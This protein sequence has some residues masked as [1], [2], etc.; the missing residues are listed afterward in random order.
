MSD[1]RDCAALR[2]EVERLEA[3]NRWLERRVVQVER[4]ARTTEE[5]HR[6][7]Q[8]ALSS[9]HERLRA[10]NESLEEALLAKDRFLAT[11]SH[12]IRTPM[13]GVIGFI[14]LLQGMELEAE[15]AGMVGTLRRS[16]ETLMALLNDVLDFA[17]IEAG[18]LLLEST[19]F[20][21]VDRLEDLREL[22]R[23]R[24]V[25]KGIRI[26]VEVDERVA[27]A[28]VGDPLR[29]NQVLT[30]LVSNAIKFTQEG[31]VTLRVEPGSAPDQLRFEVRDSG[32]GMTAQERDRIFRPFTQADESTSRRFGGTGLGLAISLALVRVMGGRLEVDST[33]GGGSTF[34]FEAHLPAAEAVAAGTSERQLRPAAP[35][36][37]SGLE[38]LVVDDNPTNR[39]L[40]EKMLLRLG[41]RPTTVDGGAVAVSTAMERAF[42]VILMD[43]SMP[44]VDGFEATRRIRALAA[45]AC[46]VPIVAMTALT[47]AGD[48]ERCAAAGMDGYLAKPVRLE[49]LEETLEALLPRARRVSA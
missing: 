37:L 28:V 16:A 40:A 24:C 19:P 32:I 35:S 22:H 36:A 6:Q 43:G 1:E 5:M 45:P 21:L 48:R 46:N 33:P 26:D 8:H 3:R 23:G 18:G 34:R 44:D 15:A 9:S 11:M 39:L 14:D 7:G 41:C 30:N 49:A 29:L 10:A 27:R 13:N 12:E 31:G 38:V 47:L 17:R 42:D 25:E 20:A 2:A 4:A